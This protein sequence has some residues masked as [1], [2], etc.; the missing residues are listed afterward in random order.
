MPQ[1]AQRLISSESEGINTL[2]LDLRLRR[3]FNWQFLVADIQQPILKADFLRHY[4]LLGY[5]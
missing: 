4:S 5:D 3:A 1:M 2:I